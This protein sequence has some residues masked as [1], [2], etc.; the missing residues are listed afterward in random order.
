MLKT[1]RSAIFRKALLVMLAMV[2]F[3]ALLLSWMAVRSGLQA[4]ETSTAIADFLSEREDDLRALAL[5]GFSGGCGFIHFLQFLRRHCRYTI[6]QM[7]QLSQ[8]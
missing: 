1:F 8:L 3:P 6:L 7:Q 2:L 5:P 4:G